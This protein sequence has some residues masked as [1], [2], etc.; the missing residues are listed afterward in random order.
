MDFLKTFDGRDKLLT[1]YWPQPFGSIM[2]ANCM[3]NELTETAWQLQELV[4]G[5]TA[6][7]IWDMVERR[8]EARAE[9]RAV[10]DALDAA[11]KVAGDRAVIE[12]TGTIWFGGKE[13]CRWSTKT[14]TWERR[15]AWPGFAGDLKIDFDERLKQSSPA[16]RRDVVRPRRSRP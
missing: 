11:H 12:T 3:K 5:R 8:P 13:A 6:P 7:P 2:K 1:P 4:E 16:S 9:R 14:R 10:Q 15:R